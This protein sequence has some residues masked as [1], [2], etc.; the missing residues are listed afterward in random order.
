MLEINMNSFP[1]TVSAVILSFLVL[2]FMV[3][4]VI[5][6]I[7]STYPNMHLLAR[8]LIIIFASA[9]YVVVINWNKVQRYP[10][11][12]I[13][14]LSIFIV[15]VLYIPFRSTPFGLNGIWGDAWFVTSSITKFSQNW[16]FVD[17][18]YKGLP[19]FYPPLYFY[20]LGKISLFLGKAPYLMVRYGVFLTAFLLPF[21]VFSLWRQIVSREAAIIITFLNFLVFNGLLLYKPYEFISLSLFVPWWLYYVER[22]SGESIKGSRV[23]IGGVIGALLFQTYYY[24]FFIGGLSLIL[25]ILIHLG[26]GESARKIIREFVLKIYVLIV[27]AALSLPYWGPLLYS[28]IKFG[29]EPLQ[30][31]W[32]TPGHINFYIPFFNLNF[33]GV[34]LL[35]GFL[36]LIFV[37]NKTT[38]S[39]KLLL[40]ACYIWYLVGYVMIIAFNLPILHVKVN[41]MINT[42]L[43]PAA[44]LAIWSLLKEAKVRKIIKNTGVAFLTAAFILFTLQT[45]ITGVERNKLL[46]NANKQKVN[47]KLA[48]TF[49][50]PEYKGKVFLTSNFELLAYAPVYAFIVNNAHYSHPAARFHE[51]LSFLE[52]LS[53][54][55]NPEEFARKL[56]NNKYSKIDYIWLNYKDGKYH[57]NISDDNFPNGGKSVHISFD[58]KLFSSQYFE[59]IEDN[60]YV[61]FKLNPESGR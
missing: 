47:V 20:V 58:G 48:K 17:F 9:I 7:P 42:V 37:N 25:N 43:M 4:G 13:C 3:K 45:Y 52:S 32:F 38:S 26:A 51:R 56:A 49:N 2:V 24:Y 33:S 22:V 57:L 29:S 30:N 46:E 10:L 23:F 50:K 60:G 15:A 16:S 61:L 27:S 1:R 53:K 18:T 36:Y 44:G 54:I 19:S 41:Q 34:I 55:D 21:A 39:L 11:L 35:G 59:R 12:V 31:R 40:A 8:T 5:Q 6:Q 14:L 28:L